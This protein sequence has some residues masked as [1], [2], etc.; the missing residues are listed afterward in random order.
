MLL[1]ARTEPEELIIL[2]YLNI[3]KDLSEK[4]KSHYNY[5]KKGYEGEMKFDQMS[6]CLEEERY[7]LQDLL[8]EV[9]N[10]YFQ[11]DTLIISQV[12]IHLIDIKNFE[13]NCYL[14]DDKLFSM[15]SGREYKNPVIQLKRSTTLFRQLLQKLKL[16]F[17]VEGSVI[18]INSEFTLYQAPMD[19]PIVLPTQVKQFLK[20]MN[21]V[22]SKLNDSHKKLGQTLLSLHQTKSPY[23]TPPTYKY[24][25]MRKGPYCKICDSFDVFIKN[26]HLVCENCDCHEK[27]EDAI[28]RFIKEFSFL[29]PDMKI[30]TKSI[31]EWC[32][33]NLSDKTYYRV[34]KK[35]YDTCGSTSN[36]YYK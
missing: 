13:G 34:L 35:H 29:F 1:K 10:S 2:R 9:N 5:L 22:P 20:D 8:L 15:T 23:Y 11:I 33:M 26:F 32:Q 24:G 7:I 17:L 6:E 14:E 31:R 4:E 27:I 36:T 3:R 18:F 16:N 19:Q 30:T 28:L 12:N 25:E 21:K